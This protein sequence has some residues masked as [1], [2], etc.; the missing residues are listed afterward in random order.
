M[1]RLIAWSPWLVLVAGAA[2]LSLAYP[3]LP[4]DWV[5][6]YDVS[7]QPDA[8]IHK[9]WG[10]ALFPLGLGAFI[11]LVLEVVGRAVPVRPPFALEESWRRRLQDWQQESLRLVACGVA[12][13]MVLMAAILPWVH[14]PHLI[15]LV[16]VGMVLTALVV[17][18]VT[19]NRL[20]ARMGQAGVLPAGYRGLIYRNPEDP[21]LL[22][23]RLTGGGTTLNLAHFKAWLLLLALLAVPALILGLTLLRGS[24]P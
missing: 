5:V 2:L 19:L 1:S 22:V 21:R 20:M 15:L 14:T 12:L 24:V 16:V 10:A 8:W 6:H 17:P 13:A 3:S 18:A 7:G 11:C 23:P 9:S 4:L